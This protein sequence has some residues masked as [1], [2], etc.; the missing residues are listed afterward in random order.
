[1]SQ[2]NVL[3]YCDIF[4]ATRLM[5]SRRGGRGTPKADAVR[6]LSKGG[7]VKMQTR[8]GQKIRKF[9]R[10]HMY[11]APY[12]LWAWPI[13][14]AGCRRTT[15]IGVGPSLR[16]APPETFVTNSNPADGLRT[17]RQDAADRDRGDRQKT[18]RMYFGLTN[19]ELVVM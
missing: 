7:C 6:K 11:M 8:G 3:L 13:I 5:S 2:Y 10:R 12:V 16:A 15:R 4:S 18:L 1:M 14:L 19:S 17:V 9:C